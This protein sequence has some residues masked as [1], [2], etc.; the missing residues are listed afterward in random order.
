M[1]LKINKSVLINLVEGMLVEAVR[2][3]A[4]D[5]HVVPERWKQNGYHFS[6][7]MAIYNCGTRKKEFC[8]K[9]FAPL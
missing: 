4:S 1:K 7:S 8:R 9:L 6:E 3:D 5:I 2:K